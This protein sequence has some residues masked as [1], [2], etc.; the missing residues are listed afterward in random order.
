MTVIL[1]SLPLRFTRTS[2]SLWPAGDN[3]TSAILAS[4]MTFGS[5]TGTETST[6]G[7]GGGGASLHPITK[8]H[9]NRRI[10]PTTTRPYETLHNSLSM[11]VP[12]ELF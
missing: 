8:A 9:I 10:W 5:S 1:P 3:T 7:G 11:I 4:S 2:S 12:H 6:T